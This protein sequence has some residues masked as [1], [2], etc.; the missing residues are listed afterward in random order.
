MTARK[1]RPENPSNRAVLVTVH[2]KDGLVEDNTHNRGYIAGY[3]PTVDYYS[4]TYHRAKRGDALYAKE[5]YYYPTRYY[6]SSYR[7]YDIIDVS[8]RV[9][10][11]NTH[12]AVS[13]KRRHAYRYTGNGDYGVRY[14]C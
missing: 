3:T 13:K 5:T 9:A 4:S 14:R 11:K 7:D 10:V 8:P 1:I 2:P 6:N 12:P